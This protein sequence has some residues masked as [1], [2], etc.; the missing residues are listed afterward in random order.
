MSQ[1]YKYA[2]VIKA[3][4]DGKEIQYK[5]PGFDWQDFDYDALKS[6]FPVHFKHPNLEWRI[7]PLLII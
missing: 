6:T 2:D 7:K 5:P 4:A 3:W 1:P